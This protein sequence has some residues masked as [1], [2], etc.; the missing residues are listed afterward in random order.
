MEAFPFIW[1]KDVDLR[2]PDLRILKYLVSHGH[3]ALQDRL[4]GGFQKQ[5][6]VIFYGRPADISLVREVDDD[7]IFGVSR[8]GVGC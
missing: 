1:K 7:R 3:E 5:V 2:D 6:G 4:S 8:Y